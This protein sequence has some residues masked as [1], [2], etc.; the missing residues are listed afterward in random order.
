MKKLLV[1]ILLF[2]LLAPQAT[3][4]TLESDNYRIRFGNFNMT[5]GTKS[6]AN[7]TLTDTVGQT[8]AGEF[9]STGYTIKTGFQYMY[10]LYEFS[11][12]ISDLLIDLGELKPHTFASDTNTLTVSAPGPGYA[13]TAYENHPF[14]NTKEQEIIDTKCNDNSCNETLAA[15][16]TNKSKTG[17]GFNIKGDDTPTDFVS[18]SY[19]RQFANAKENEIPQVVMSSSQAIKNHA[20]EVTYQA[21]IDDQQPAGTY[22]NIITYIATPKL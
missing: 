19:F 13:V 21:N 18:N 7:F 22:E 8:A 3:A 12:T 14:Q 16:W 4:E 9:N 17:F 15:L 10:T 1:V 11:F 5:S 20:A 6:S 2:S